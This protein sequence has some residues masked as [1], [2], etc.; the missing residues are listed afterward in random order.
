MTDRQPPTGRPE[1]SD[2]PFD[3]SG[4][5]SMAAHGA[6]RRRLNETGVWN[7]GAQSRMLADRLAHDDAHEI[8][9]VLMWNARPSPALAAKLEAWMGAG[10]PL[11]G[12]EPR[13][14]Q[15]PRPVR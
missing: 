11:P 2:P 1:G 14:H 15:T 4:H 8:W 13:P 12:L 6:L 5:L 3:A 10:M 7:P 9:R